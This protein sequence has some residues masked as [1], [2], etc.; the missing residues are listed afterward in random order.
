MKRR[1]DALGA[2]GRRRSRA[3]IGLVAAGVLALPAIGL[4][5][6]VNSKIPNGYYA[7][8]EHAHVPGGEDVEF[9]LHRHSYLTSLT[10]TC[11]P[12]STYANLIANSGYAQILSWA[13]PKRLTLSHGSFSYSGP[14]KVTA[15]YA[16]APKVGTATLTI[17]GH[18]VRNGHAYHYTGTI[19]NK[20][21]ATLIFQGTAT[22]TACTGLPAN[23]G[24]RL[25]HTVSTA[26]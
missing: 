1:P 13:T 21:T 20:V 11:N 23:H 3:A 9:T 18:Y 17:K 15:A 19:D 14:A 6:S 26:G 5:A 4:A 12:D 2:T 25:Y 16:G 22:S 8:V 10:L 7:T 24:F